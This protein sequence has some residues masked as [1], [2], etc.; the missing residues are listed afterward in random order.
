MNKFWLG[1]MAGLTV[2]I[3]VAV[4]TMIFMGQQ[5][6]AK[7]AEAY[8]QGKAAGEVLRDG[9]DQ[10]ITRTLNQGLVQENEY[11]RNALDTATDALSTIAETDDAATARTTATNAL[12]TIQGE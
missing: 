11:M 5:I 4:G 12:N 2:G 1:L 3:A 8:E 10:A 7:Q 9:K 6:T